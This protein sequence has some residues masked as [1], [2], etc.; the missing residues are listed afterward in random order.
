[1]SSGVIYHIILD[2]YV[3]CNTREHIFLTAASFLFREFLLCFD[4]DS[5]HRPFNVTQHNDR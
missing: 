4:G 2:F 5:W 1:M 3:Y